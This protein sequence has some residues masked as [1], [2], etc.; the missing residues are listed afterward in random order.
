[1]IQYVLCDEPRRL[2]NASQL[3]QR[4]IEETRLPDCRVSDDFFVEKNSSTSNST[5]EANREFCWL[6]LLSKTVSMAIFH[7]C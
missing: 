2:A 5:V 3:K 1:M 4:H 7:F 6:F